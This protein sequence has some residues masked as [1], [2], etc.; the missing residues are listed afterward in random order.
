M[1]LR[2][3]TADERLAEERLKKT[4]VIFGRSGFGKTTLL[5]TLPVAA[6]LGL[7]SEA[8]GKS[9]QDRRDDTVAIRPTAG[10]A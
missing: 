6:A 1:A 9:V 10:S 8:A 4:V 2:I 7:D 5:G 3:I